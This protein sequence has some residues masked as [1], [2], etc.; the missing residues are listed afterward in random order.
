MMGRTFF[1]FAVIAN[2][3][4]DHTLCRVQGERYFPCRPNYGVFVR[5]DRV[6]VGDFAV[7][8]INFDDEEM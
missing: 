1:S 2:H 5:P 7:E 4:R 3:Y 6:S 8:E